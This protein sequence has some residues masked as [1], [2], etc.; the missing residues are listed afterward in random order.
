MAACNGF[1][2]FYCVAIF[3]SPKGRERLEEGKGEGEFQDGR[4]EE[5]RREVSHSANGRRKGEFLGKT[6]ETLSTRIHASPNI[7]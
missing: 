1:I 6:Q 7:D 3:G 4:E 5:K 2:F